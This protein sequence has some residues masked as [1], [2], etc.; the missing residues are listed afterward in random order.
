MKIL[1]K[2]MQGI[3][4][5]IYARPFIKML[6]EDGHEVFLKTVLPFMYG[7]LNVKFVKVEATLRSQKKSLAGST[8]EM[9][10][11]PD[12]DKII[13]FFYSAQDM[14]AY[15][16]ISHLEK[17]FGYEVGSTMPIFDLPHLPAH[18]IDV[19]KLKKLAIVRPVT[20]RKEWLC[21]SRSP[22]AN[23]VAW[24]A[25]ILKDMGY[26]VISIA[27][28]EAGQEWIEEDG[29]PIADQKFHKGELGL[30]RTLS[31]IQAAD[32]VVGGS[33]FIVP[34]TISAGTNLFII[35]GGR[36]GYDNPHKILDLRMDLK[37]IGWALPNNF[38]RCKAMEHD[39]NKE[40]KDLDSQF[41]R[42]MRNV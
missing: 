31:L 35:F 25:K 28:C 18:G 17:V 9:L 2:C 39:C 42:F 37:K 7:D 15:G 16:I 1:V 36:G 34:A 30:E 5:S 32:I 14:K 13:D 21:S 6:V 4:D 24:C 23:Y 40:I 29:D 33:G 12:V 41:F 10:A 38:C 19:P 22:N 3:G 11:E 20:H 8:Y 27:D 26:Y